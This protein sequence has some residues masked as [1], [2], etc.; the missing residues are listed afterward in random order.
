MTFDDTAATPDQVFQLYEDRT[1]S[2]EYATRSDSASLPYENLLL[3]GTILVRIFVA[4][5]P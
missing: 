3:R 4:L 1:G 2:M 5:V